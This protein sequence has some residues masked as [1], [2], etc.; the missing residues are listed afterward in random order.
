MHICY[1]DS[2]VESYL[3]GTNVVILLSLVVPTAGK[4]NKSFATHNSLITA[5]VHLVHATHLPGM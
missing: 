5:T 4:P 2:Q 1:P 3:L